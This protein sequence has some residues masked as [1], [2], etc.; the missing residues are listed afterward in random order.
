MSSNRVVTAIA[1]IIGAL[2]ANTQCVAQASLERSNFQKA[3]AWFQSRCLPYSR[4]VAGEMKE[5]LTASERAL[6]DTIEIECVDDLGFGAFAFE[7]DGRK[8]ILIATGTIV[9]LELAATASALGIAYGKP[10][11]GA[12]F[13]EAWVGWGRENMERA[14]K[15]EAPMSGEN[16]F[17]FARHNRE[18]C[19]LVTET[20][21]RDNPRAADHR[22]VL[23]NGGL[24]FILAHELGHHILGHARMPPSSSQESRDRE[25]AADSFALKVV[26]KAGHSP[27]EAVMA[28]GLLAALDDFSARSP[29]EATHPAGK[30]RLAT[31]TSVMKSFEG[32]EEF[33]EYIREDPSRRHLWEKAIESMESMAEGLQ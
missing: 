11:C 25:R 32:T 28:L 1:V 18:Y 27:L 12:I 24:R 29:T 31:L 6:F 7:K 8:K 13:L 9:S 4:E 20:Q 2:G 21:F 19:P 14:F 33:R 23:I 22:E 3:M 5:G 30:A 26:G 17:A 15:G 16:P 10:L